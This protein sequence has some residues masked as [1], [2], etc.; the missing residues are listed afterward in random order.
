MK[1]FQNGFDLVCLHAAGL[2]VA[3]L[4]A[5][6]LDAVSLDVAG[7]DVAKGTKNCMA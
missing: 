7:L 2:D 5:A 1:K 6:S 4:V 3:S